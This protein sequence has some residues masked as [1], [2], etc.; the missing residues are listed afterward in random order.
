LKSHRVLDCS[1]R[2]KSRALVSQ[3]LAVRSL[4]LSLCLPPTV[5][6]AGQYKNALS[7][8]EFCEKTTK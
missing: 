5:L 6:T 7:H 2:L 8:G 1:A 3:S 4:A